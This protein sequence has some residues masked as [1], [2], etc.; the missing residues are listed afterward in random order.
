MSASPLVRADFG[1]FFAALH[2]GAA[3]FAWQVRLLDTVLDGGRWPDQVVAP[4][5]AG[6]TAVIDVHV[7]A[8]ALTAGDPVAARPPR[9]LALVVGRRVLVDDQYE[10]ARTLADR[11]VAPEDRVLAAVADRLWRM[12]DP[13]A[14]SNT[15]ANTAADAD[16]DATGDLAVTGVRG[17]GEVSPLVLGRLRGGTPPSRVWRDHVGAAA[18]ICATPEMWGSRVLFRGYGSDRRA[19]PREAGLLAVDSVVV[20]DEAHLARQLLVTARR[21]A[22]L[23]RVA[24]EPV[25]WRPLQVVE[26]TA[27]PAVAGP[28]A[29]PGG[30]GL[31]A[32]GVDPPD[33]DAAPVLADRL[34]R[35]KPVRVLSVAGWDSKQDKARR[36]VVTRIA[37]AVEELLVEDLLPGPTGTEGATSDGVEVS[38]ASAVTHTVGCFVNTVRRA[39]EV[40]AELGG[41]SRDGR[42][43][44]VVTVCGQTRPYDLDRLRQLY[45]GLLTP[46]GNHD[47]DVIVS[48]QSLE[49]GVD[50]DLAGLVTELAPGSALAQRAGRVNRR[51]LRTAGPVVVIAPDQDPTADTR[52]GPYL[53]PDLAAALTWVRERAVTDAGMAPWALRDTPPPTPAGR[54]ILLQRPEL[55]D[56]WHWART[57]DDLA[58]EPELALWLEEDFDSDTTVGFI[59][60]DALPVQGDDA[61]RLLN[62][63]PVQRHEVFPVPY[64]TALAT[65]AR[66]TGAGQT[67]TP[68]TVRVSGQDTTV[69][70]WRT[71][72]S[73]PD[74]EVPQLRPGDVVVLDSGTAVF[75][76]SPDPA[77]FTPPVV[78]PMAGEDDGPVPA[79]TADDVLTGQAD[80]TGWPRRQTG[81]VVLR[82]EA[83]VA[84]LDEHRFALL[85]KPLAEIL[86]DPDAARQAT[87]QLVADWLTHDA[88]EAWAMAPA[89]QTLLRGHPK[90]S[91]VVVHRD[92]DA[93]VRRVLVR[94]RR[95]A[96]AEEHLRQ[97][98]TPTG[99]TVTLT[100]HQHDVAQRVT[101]IA[102]DLDVPA[103]VVNALQHAAVHHDDGKQDPRF[104]VRLGATDP[105]QLLAKSSAATTATQARSN[106]RACGLPAGW[107]HEQ[108][109]VLHAW[110][111]L[112]E[113]AEHDLDPL[114][115]AR[116][117]GTSHGHGRTGFPHTTADLLLD[118]H[119]TDALTE[120]SREL[121]DTGGWDDLVERTHRRYGLWG[122]AYLE[123]VLRAAD[124]QISQ[125]GR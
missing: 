95:R 4:T 26:T 114:L 121:F 15:A 53:G 25:P 78:R 108:L 13:D 91:E 87:E 75:A 103:A 42:P 104:Q 10:Y 97:T 65:L 44:R 92:D 93:T 41:R 72:P 122:C 40:S 88:P 62:D 86:D 57:S 89:A 105:D 55:F 24:D 81:N 111:P 29:T 11:L 123:A 7:F 77:R 21:V 63:L 117:V 46:A 60:R 39:V 59:V 71:D 30:E 98:W 14:H 107:R 3:P 106:E 19:W 94:D 100:A 96:G 124:G 27:T 83:G 35:P 102:T 45:P 17:R 80:L 51:G 36:L 101:R 61:V 113:A 74:R 82:I 5:G 9:R 67:A 48:T 2:D 23:V 12:R 50:L 79:R 49:V 110:T 99:T 20:V 125:E 31:L 6:K 116:L 22:D 76:A 34:T 32:V 38:T 69:L 33:L 8:Q 109:S 43:L 118:S 1:D 90:H 64:R 56:A 58:A 37:D 16:A 115:A 85:A 120:T 47:V 54:R 28:G 84:D 66:P 52:S 119:G 68:V 112:H 73:D 18:V 70:T